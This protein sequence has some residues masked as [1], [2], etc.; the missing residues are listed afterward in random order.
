MT[1]SPISAPNIL[2]MGASGTGKTWILRTLVEAG[3]TPFIL[4]LD[5]QGLEV[6][7]DVPQDKLHWH[8]I[9]P[10]AN[11]WDFMVG[12]AKRMATFTYDAITKAQDLN[13]GSK[14]RRYINTLETLAN[15]KSDRDG[16]EYGAVDSWGTDR[17]IVLDHMTELS[18]AAKEWG[19]GNK[20]ILHEGEWQICMNT[21]ENLI[22]QLTIVCRCWVIVIAHLDRE[23]DLV[24]GT[25]RIMISTLGKKLAPKFPALFSDV[26]HAERQV[27]EFWWSTATPE[28]DLK[29]RNLPFDLKITPGF[30]QIVEAWKK[31]GGIIEKAIEG[32]P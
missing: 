3:I 25:T 17:C 12:E 6:V 11:T 24:R 30:G 27:K 8:V 14:Q 29:T 23:P 26:I 15:F 28:T 1:K 5:P 13:K 4:S 32:A 19:V 22:R 2:L 20:L 16:K 10:E 18:Q 9:R 31:R 21:V 7:G